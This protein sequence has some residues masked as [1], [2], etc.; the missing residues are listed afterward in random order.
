VSVEPNT[1]E[2]RLRRIDERFKTNRQITKGDWDWLVTMAGV[3]AST[4][5]DLLDALFG[6]KS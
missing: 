1:N 2:Q 4:P 6:V 5:P 3:A